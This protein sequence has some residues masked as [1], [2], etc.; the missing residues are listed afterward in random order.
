MQLADQTVH[1][2]PLAISVGSWVWE[3]DGYGCKNDPGNDGLADATLPSADRRGAKLNFPC[4]KTLPDGTFELPGLWLE[5]GSMLRVDVR[6]P[7]VDRPVKAVSG[8][9]DEVEI[10]LEWE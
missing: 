10:V 1:A 5:P 4:T 3:G 6:R 9:E 8:F 2:G 7:G